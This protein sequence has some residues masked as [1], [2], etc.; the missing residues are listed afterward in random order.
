M[1][2]NPFNHYKQCHTCWRP[3]NHERVESWDL[4]R[5]ADCSVG[6]S[7]SPGRDRIAEEQRW[8]TKIRK[9]DL[10]P[11][12]EM[13]HVSSPERRVTTCMGVGIL[14]DVNVT[15][16]VATVQMQWGG[17]C[18]TPANRLPELLDAHGK[19]SHS[20]AI[21]VDALIAF[22]YD[23]NCWEWPTW[24]VV[25][26]I[27]QPA[28]YNTRCR[29]VELSEMRPYVGKAD[30]FMSHCWTAKFGDLVAAASHGAK[31]NRRVWIDIFA[32]R[33]FPGNEADIDFRAVIN[34]CNSLIVSVSPDPGLCLE[35]ATTD[36]ANPASI[37]FLR[38]WCVV[39]IAAAVSMGKPIVVQGGHAAKILNSTIWSYDT[40]SLGEMMNNLLPIIDVEASECAVQADKIRELDIIRRLEGG[41]NRVQDIIVGV[42]SGA[43][44]TLE[45]GLM[46][47]DAAVCGETQ[48]LQHFCCAHGSAAKEPTELGH[49]IRKGILLAAATGGRDEIL[50]M[51]LNMWKGNHE[52]VSTLGP[53]WLQQLIDSSGVIWHT[54]SAGHYKAVATLLQVE[55]V[56]INVVDDTWNNVTAVD[57]YKV[58]GSTAFFVA[59]QNQH[60][61]TIEF[62]LKQVK[63]DPNCPRDDG[64]TPLL[65]AC[66]LGHRDVALRLLDIDNIDISGAESFREI[67]RR[68]ECINRMIDPSRLGPPRVVGKW[69]EGWDHDTSTLYYTNNENGCIQLEKPIKFEQIWL[70]TQDNLSTGKTTMSGMSRLD[71]LYFINCQEFDQQKS[72]EIE[73]WGGDAIDYKTPIYLACFHGWLSVVKQLL[74]HTDTDNKTPLLDVDYD[75]HSLEIA[76]ISEHFQIVLE[77]LKRREFTFERDSCS[78]L[79][80][81]CKDG[82]FEIVFAFLEID[83]S[84]INTIPRRNISNMESRLS[85]TCTF[86]TEDFGLCT[87][88]FIACKY[89]RSEIVCELLKQNDIDVNIPNENNETPLF[90]SCYCGRSEIFDQLLLRNDL[91]VNKRNIKNQSPLDVL[92]DG[93]RNIILRAQGCTQNTLNKM[94]ETLMQHPDIRIN[95]DSNS[96]QQVRSWLSIFNARELDMP[97]RLSSEDVLPEFTMSTLISERQIRLQESFNQAVDLAKHAGDA[98]RAEE[99]EKALH[100][101]KKSITWFMHVCKYDKYKSKHIMSSVQGYMTR[102]EEIKLFLSKSRSPW[103]LSEHVDLPED[104]PP[105]L[106]MS[107]SVST[108]PD[109]MGFYDCQ[110]EWCFEQGKIDEVIELVQKLAIRRRENSDF[111][112]SQFQL[113][114]DCHY[115]MDSGSFDKLLEAVRKI[116]VLAVNDLFP[117]AWQNTYHNESMPDNEDEFQDMVSRLMQGFIDTAVGSTSSRLANNVSELEARLDNLNQ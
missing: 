19:R 31:A 48:S 3:C 70:E 18:F 73:R 102:A 7:V 75:F 27:I 84:T 100:L 13:L 92:H 45:F 72:E 87:P 79:W 38:L 83:A 21:T 24:R 95:T 20:S 22:A 94:K 82:Y 5:C 99:Y 71:R 85:R 59:C 77:L 9:E 44:Q 51:I 74:Q 10:Q 68:R 78:V 101:Y 52:C 17:V 25:R 115:N 113:M 1:K 66:Q 69:E 81:A 109:T 107:S 16:R 117:V 67:K 37:P 60:M 54:S 116:D 110:I 63:V 14:Q 23:H 6:P 97:L 50:R 34:R 2:R 56:N 86:M 90:I 53:E 105:E 57:A 33:Q 36:V 29:Y 62:L 96:I 15:A 39:E 111:V 64:V 103:F 35:S 58:Y 41:V 11:L 88:L 108:R 28:T 89:G 61:E 12:L 8:A 26:D 112:Y 4:T 114:N 104:V 65:Y 76:Y 91:D 55:N 47:V 80:N 106:T 93:H 98:D 30:V 43:I 40:D 42:I 32:V 46:E 49:E